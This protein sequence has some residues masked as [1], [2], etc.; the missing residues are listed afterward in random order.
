MGWMP[1][2]STRIRSSTSPA[3]GIG[4]PCRP[5]PPASPVAWSPGRSVARAERPLALAPEER[6]ERHSRRAGFYWSHEQPESH[7]ARRF[8]RD[9]LSVRVIMPRHYAAPMAPCNRD[10][11]VRRS[12]RRDSSIA[13]SARSSQ[14]ARPCALPLT[15]IMHQGPDPVQR[16]F[17]IGVFSRCCQVSRSG[18]SR[19][20]FANPSV[21]RGTVLAPVRDTTRVRRP[22]TGSAA[23]FLPSRRWAARCP[24]FL[25]VRAG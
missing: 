8:N 17:S 12:W 25:P 15:R 9:D 7:V 13:R 5:A 16:Q 2:T 6:R 18:R 21:A 11:T 19:E 1:S 23:L 14:A 22:S 10:N 3:G 24:P 4:C 20:G